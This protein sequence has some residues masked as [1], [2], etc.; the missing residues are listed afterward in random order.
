M[1]SL[2]GN[3]AEF[4]ILEKKLED[5]IEQAGDTEIRESKM[6]KADLAAKIGDVTRAMKEYDETLEMTV[7]AGYQIELVGL[8]IC[9]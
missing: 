1:F 8:F 6:A 9:V 7:G 3:T 4:A 2:T 5:S